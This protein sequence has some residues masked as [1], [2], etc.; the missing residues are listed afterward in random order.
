MGTGIWGVEARDAAKHPTVLW[1]APCNR[2]LPAAN[3][4]SDEIGKFCSEV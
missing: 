2:E 4:G 1:K 3:V